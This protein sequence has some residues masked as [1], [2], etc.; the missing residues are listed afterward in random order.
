MSQAVL[1][2]V[3][4]NSQ[5]MKY[6]SQWY[7]S[8]QQLQQQQPI[9]TAAVSQSLEITGPQTQAQVAYDRHIP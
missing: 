2:N 3:D 7:A 5:W 6:Y 4:G 8:N 1:P 9:A